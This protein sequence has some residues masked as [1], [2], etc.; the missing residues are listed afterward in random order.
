ML[1]RSAEN[2]IRDTIKTLKEGGREV[3]REGGHFSERCRIKCSATGNSVAK[4]RLHHPM[5]G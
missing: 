2:G 4:K 1:F 3:G 5:S